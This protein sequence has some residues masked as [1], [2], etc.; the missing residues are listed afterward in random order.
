MKSV[1][2]IHGTIVD[3]DYKEGDKLDDNKTTLAVV[4]DMSKLIF[5]MDVDELDISSV[6]Q[7]MTVEVTAD[8]VSGELFE[9]IIT[10]VGILGATS[11]GVTTYPVEVEIEEYGRLLP[12]MNVNAEIVTEQVTDVLMVP[13]TAVQ[14]NNMV[15]V[16]EA[17]AQSMG[18]EIIEV[19]Q[20]R[21]ADMT[22]ALAVQ[23]D[24]LLEGYVYLLVAVGLNDDDYVEITAGLTEGAKVYQTVAVTVDES[25]ENGMMM[26]GMMPGMTGDGPPSGAGGGGGMRRGQ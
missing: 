7:G 18:A 25:D 13:L 1:S 15:I 21:K 14:R 10:K 8:A 26:P 19:S 3:K 22:T 20:L 23:N 11:D 16:T 9:G 12:G 6:S 24:N 5:E 2:P 17:Y 4:A